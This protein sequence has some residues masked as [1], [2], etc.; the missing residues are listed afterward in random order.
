VKQFVNVAVVQDAAVAFDKKATLDHVERLLGEA[1]ATTPDLVLF[2]EAFVP[3]YPSG[4]DWGGPGAGVRAD[5]GQF[6]YVRYMDGA[7]TVPG[8]EADQLGEF[9][10][11]YGINLVIGVI[12]KMSSTLCCSVLH[13]DRSGELVHVRRKLMPTMAERTVWGQS[14]GA[15][16]SA[17]AFD[18]GRTGTVICWEN[19]MPLMRQAIYAQDIA[20]YCAPT[21]DD[22]EAWV[23]SMRH[24]ALEGRCFVLSACQFSTRRDFPVEY[25]WFPSEDP[26]F[27]VSRG[28]SCIVDP[29]GNLLVEP[30]YDR[31]AIL[32]ARLDMEMV[33]RGRHSFDVTGHYARPDIF[34]LTVNREKRQSVTFE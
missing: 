25:G 23:P 22:M 18:I 2:P 21:A 30:V 24:I 26:D 12:E 8:P 11:Q 31:A 7:I 4:M 9:A 34:R 10:K 20:I 1:M 6:D 13:F 19:Y 32:T 29:F 5:A 17:V 27:I 3:G 28:G 15:S 14:D 33:T 16:I